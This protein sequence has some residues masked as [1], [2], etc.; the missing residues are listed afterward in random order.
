[1]VCGNTSQPW[2]YRGFEKFPSLYFAAKPH[3]DLSNEELD[4]I[5]KFQLAYVEEL[6]SYKF[7][8]F[9]TRFEYQNHSIIEFRANQFD[10][11]DSGTKKWADGDEA[12][13]E[14]RQC[15]ALRARH[16][17]NAPPCFV[18]RNGQWAGTMYSMQNQLLRDHQDAFVGSSDSSWSCSGQVDY[19]LNIVDEPTPSSGISQCLFDMRQQSARTVFQEI[20][21]G[22][23]NESDVTA[24]VFIDNGE[25]IVC[26]NEEHLTS[27]SEAER[28]EMQN[29]TFQVYR[30]AIQSLQSSNKYLILSTPNRY[31]S[32]SHPLVPWESSCPH[33]EEE[34]VGAMSDLPF[35]RNF[36]FFMWN[37]GSTCE[38]HIKNG[39]LERQNG[40]PLIVHTP[41]FAESKGCSGGCIRSD[42]NRV[43][44]TEQEFLS[45][46]MAAFLVV[47]GKGSYFGFSQM[48][49][50]N[51]EYQLGGWADVSWPYY[52]LYDTDFGAPTADPV[53]VSS[54]RF[55]RQFQNGIAM[56]DCSTGEYSLPTN[57]GT[58][59]NTSNS[60]STLTWIAVSCA[61]VAIVLTGLF[62]LYWIWKRTK[63]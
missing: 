24:G 41:Y 33:R 54:M 57:G 31:S 48:D 20:I 56:I 7:T 51:D 37:L 58:T 39:M 45:L 26:D 60:T 28:R 9:Y 2:T 5:A 63:R 6:K 49:D 43:N 19:P 55:Q 46:T 13:A 40:V 62:V 27:F 23:N 21:T 42:G 17:S 4:K 30:D 44:Y 12:G 35:A 11:E 59:S 8:F 3:G 34:L 10:G 16:G 1:M 61:S 15:E 50:P 29:R 32:V 14:V 53:E 25:S 18:Y 52:S 36:E 22:V 38:S 47:Y